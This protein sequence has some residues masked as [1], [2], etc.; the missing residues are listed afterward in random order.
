MI[1]IVTRILLYKQYRRVH[2][3]SPPWEKVYTQYKG[4]QQ[5][6]R[7]LAG[8]VVDDLLCLRAIGRR[9]NRTVRPNFGFKFPEKKKPENIHARTLCVP[10]GFTYP[11]TRR[12]ICNT[13][14]CAQFE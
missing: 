8:P 2:Y 6:R 4:R 10:A 9:L 14:I 5:T 13:A 3:Y 11:S 1:I 7:S 12:A